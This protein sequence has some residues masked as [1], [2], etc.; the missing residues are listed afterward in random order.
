MRV[1][2]TYRKGQKQLKIIA[3]HPES[4]L[5][6]PPIYDPAYAE[7]LST[8]SPVNPVGVI[9]LSSLLVSNRIKSFWKSGQ[10]L[11]RPIF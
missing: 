5:A 7:K 6:R 10:R 2:V 9:K 4:T 11:R 3:K 1:L 8:A